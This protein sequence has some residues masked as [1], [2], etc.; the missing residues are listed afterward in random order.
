MQRTCAIFGT[1]FLLA[2]APAWAGQVFRCTQAGGAVAYQEL[3]CSPGTVETSW[4]TPA[5]PE[6]NTAERDRLMQ[7]EAALDARLLKRAEIDAAERIA[8]EARR[9]REL[10]LEREAE[11]ARTVETSYYGPVYA[12]P[13]RNYP[14][15]S[16]VLPRPK[17]LLSF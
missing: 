10:A 15:R 2:A 16:P 3:P 9:E 5:F 4:Q 8:R 12:P 11:R 7:R 14:P 17:P 6:V 13:Y 1:I